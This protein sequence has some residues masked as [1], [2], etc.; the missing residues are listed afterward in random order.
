MKSKISILDFYLEAKYKKIKYTIEINENVK[1]LFI[2]GTDKKN[3]DI[4]ISM[5]FDMFIKH[6][7]QKYFGG[8]Y[9]KG[10]KSFRSITQGG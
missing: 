4:D 8:I 1:S 10:G 6:I 5:D 2:E 9:W 3:K 7:E